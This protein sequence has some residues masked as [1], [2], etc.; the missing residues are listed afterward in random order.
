MFF[1]TKSL[2]RYNYKQAVVKKDCSRN[3]NFCREINM[4]KL[5]KIGMVMV[6][7]MSMLTGCM[8]SRSEVENYFTTITKYYSTDS[9]LDIV[10]NGSYTSGTVILWSGISYY[11][12]EDL[13]S[14]TMWLWLNVETMECTGKYE[15]KYYTDNGPQTVDYALYYDG[16]YHLID[17]VE[18]EELKERILNFKFLF[19]YVEFERGYFD[20]MKTKNIGYNE[21]TDS[22]NIIY[23][24]PEGDKNIK[25]IYDNISN[26]PE[27]DNITLEFSSNLGMKIL[28]NDEN[29]TDISEDVFYK[30]K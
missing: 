7:M 27:S 11:V 17:V 10:K 13:Y 19:Q 26:L 4:K 6:I 3:A 29:G 16:G 12:G 15:V 2:L 25:A 24:M 28:F 8:K 22:Y 20:S 14:E 1:E 18:D 21:P 9:V 5:I 23:Y 30:E